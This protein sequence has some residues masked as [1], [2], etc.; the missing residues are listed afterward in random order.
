MNFNPRYN[1]RL[2]NKALQSL[3]SADNH[4]NSAIL[5]N[6]SHPRNSS[7]VSVES[8][9]EAIEQGNRGKR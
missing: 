4:Y 7:I 2:L 9:A 6:A 8:E 3:L 5:W 1:K